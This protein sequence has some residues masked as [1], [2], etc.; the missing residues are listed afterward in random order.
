MPQNPSRFLVEN[1]HMLPEGRALD[2][3]MGHGRNAVYLA[4]LG[5]EVEGV[6]IASD[7][8]D[9][10]LAVAKRKGL[11]IHAEVADLEKEYQIA[12]DTY[13]LIIC[14]NYLQ[15]SL[16]PSIEAGLKPGGMVVYETFIVDQARFGRP[17]NPDHLLKHNE[18][19][20][21]FRNLRVLRYHEGIIND[22]KAVAGIIAQKDPS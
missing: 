12:P 15:R 7:A 19:L 21:R 13:D 14:F 20:H 18:L 4:S 17:R 22:H 2:I 3:A 1:A 16:F 8:V 5:F 11:R 6:D 9:G 10:A